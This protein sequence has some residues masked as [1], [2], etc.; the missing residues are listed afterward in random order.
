[1]KVLLKIV[2][3]IVACAILAVVILSITGL[4]PQQRRAGLW[5]RGDVSSFPADWIFADKNQ[6][7]L[8]ETH[9]WYRIPHS[10]TIYFVTNQGNLYLHCSYAPGDKYPDGKTW[11]AYLARNPKV[12]VKVGNQVFD[13]KVALVTD[14]ADFNTLHEI[15]R[16]KYPQSPY[17]NDRRIPDQQFLRVLPE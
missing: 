7:I 13:G 14:A 8:V 9:P 17:S 10:V 5:L 15:F 1:M 16:M 4:D 6:T 12:R 11:T 3:A 2:G